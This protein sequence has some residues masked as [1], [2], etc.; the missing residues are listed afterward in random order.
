MTH[1]P[2][3]QPSPDRM[4]D[5]AGQPLVVEIVPGQPAL[6]ALTAAL[7]AKAV[8]APMLYCAFVDESR[9]V[10]EEFADGTVRHVPIDPD[11]L[12]E[13]WVEQSRSVQE[14]L[15]EVLDP[16]GVPWT[17][18]FLAGR[19]DRAL[20]H[21]ARAVDAS[22]FVVGTRAPGPGARVREVL[23]GSTAVRLS[24]HQ[25]RPVMVVPLEVVDWKTATWS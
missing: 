21:L 24:H 10:V 17:F 9:I 22:A 8:R 18:R 2:V 3:P 19:A 23:D 12:D 25:H 1:R 15:A 13:A 4:V 7:W 6:V 16:E 14:W 20:T 11:G 5:P